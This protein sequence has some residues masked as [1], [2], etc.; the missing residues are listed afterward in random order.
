LTLETRVRAQP[1][2]VEN[3]GC[4]F[5]DL[6]VQPACLLQEHA[7]I[8]CDSLR[9]AQQV[10]ERRSLRAHGMA[11]LLRLLE[12]LRVTEQ[13]EARA[14]RHREHAAGDIY[15][16]LMLN[17]TTNEIAH[18]AMPCRWRR[19]DS[20]QVRRLLSRRCLKAVA[21]ASVTWKPRAARR[22]RRQLSANAD[23][24]WLTVTP[25]F[26]R[27]DEPRISASP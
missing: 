5:A 10:L 1:V 26:F 22:A 9:R 11:G 19:N 20:Q 7:A 23:D 27:L 17:V 16:L 12:L 15:R 8:R 2:F 13:H 3:L 6:R 4:E 21:F 18:R 25:T 24:P 14:G